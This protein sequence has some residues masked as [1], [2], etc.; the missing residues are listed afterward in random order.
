[1]ERIL[2]IAEKHSDSAEVF[3]ISNSMHTTESKNY[4]LTN[5]ESTIQSG[6]ALRILKDGYLGTSYTKNL[7]NPEKLVQDALVSLKGKVDGS[8]QFPDKHTPKELKTYDLSIEE[9][10]NSDLIIE[11]KELSE[12]VKKRVDPKGQFNLT[13]GFG[14]F[15]KH[16]MNTNE[17]D[18]KFK[19]SF[20]YNYAGILFPSSYAHVENIT[21]SIGRQL[22]DRV[23]LDRSIELYNKS[24]KNVT[25]KS[26]DID[27]IFTPRT[28]KILLWRVRT[29]ASA[30]SIY[31]NISPIKNKIGEKIF[32]DNFTYVDDPFAGSPEDSSFDDEGTAKS[33]FSIIENGVFSGIYN[34]LDY[35]KKLGMKPTGHGYR[36]GNETVAASPIPVL[37]NQMVLPGDTSIDDMIKNTKRGV[38][39]LGDLGAHSGNIPNGDFSVGLN[40]GLYI[41]NGEVVGRIKDGMIAGNVYDIMKNIKCIE[42]ITHQDFSGKFPSLCIGD[43]KF[44]V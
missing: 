17:L 11:T 2:E 10:K 4:G 35:A 16:I 26:G 22:L 14:S 13:T 1:M 19:S 21:F 30:K 37:A 41:E 6:Y 18:V 43:V 15:Q 5:M 27:V 36:E 32:S 12:Y 31:D 44:S 9:L 23:K 29:G 28:I 24:L 25:V 7:L 34:S 39:L 8:F 42:N 3:N 33:R 38:L 20:F 40:P